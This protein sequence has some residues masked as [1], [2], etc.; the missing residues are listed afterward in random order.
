MIAVKCL[1]LEQRAYN[2]GWTRTAKALESI[3]NLLARL[4]LPSTPPCEHHT[5]RRID[6]HGNS[7]WCCNC[8]A[9]RVRQ[10]WMLPAKAVSR[11]RTISI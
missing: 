2:L 11:E 7:S 10:A 6:T 4:T 3:T 1:G 5:Q 9:L 8:G